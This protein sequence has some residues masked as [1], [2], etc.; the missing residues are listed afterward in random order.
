MGSSTDG[1]KPTGMG[2]EWGLRLGNGKKRKSL[3]KDGNRIEG[4]GRLERDLGMIY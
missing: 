1:D 4:D 3:F 2:W